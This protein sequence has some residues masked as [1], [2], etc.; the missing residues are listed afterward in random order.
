MLFYKGVVSSYLLTRL[1]VP[2]EEHNKSFAEIAA[3]NSDIPVKTGSWSNEM[4]T[5]AWYAFWYDHINKLI[6]RCW[7]YEESLSMIETL[8]AGF[9]LTPPEFI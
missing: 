4:R 1:G 7:D 8:T 2:M 9:G 6:G 5:L 3:G